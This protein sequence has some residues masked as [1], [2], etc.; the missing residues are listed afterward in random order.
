[1]AGQTPPAVTGGSWKFI[2]REYQALTVPDNTLVACGNGTSWLQKTVS[3]KFDAGNTFFGSDPAYGIQKTVL[4][5]VPDAAAVPVADPAP[6]TEPTPALP[7]AHGP[8][9][10]H[11]PPNT[12]PAAD[13]TPQ[14][15]ATPPAADTPAA[16]ASDPTPAP[17]QQPASTPP[18]TVNVGTAIVMGMIATLQALGY[19]VTKP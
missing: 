2:G 17:T 6:T 3:G 11:V 7:A 10:D 8:G 18:G 15:A 1:M 19:T 13:P 16:P 9:D 5:F 4:Q 14:P 12:P